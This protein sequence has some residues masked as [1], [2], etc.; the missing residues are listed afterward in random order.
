M[1][2]PHVLVATAGVLYLHVTGILR[3][4]EY[5]FFIFLVA[6]A[7]MFENDSCLSVNRK[8]IVHVCVL[9]FLFSEEKSNWE[10]SRGVLPRANPE[11]PEAPR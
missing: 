2:W 7:Q 4:S 9:L 1:L 3:L 8:Y 5:L 10:F 6:E 11:F